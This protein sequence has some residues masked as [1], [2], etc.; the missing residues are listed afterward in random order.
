MHLEFIRL[1]N[2][3]HTCSGLQIVRFSTEERLQAIMQTYRDFGASINDP[4]VHILEDGGKL[5]DMDRAAVAA[6]ARLA[7]SPAL[8]MKQRFDPQGL[9]NPGKLRS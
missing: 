5:R 8:A 3:A 1:T 7:S 4:H 9:L 6:A 2:G